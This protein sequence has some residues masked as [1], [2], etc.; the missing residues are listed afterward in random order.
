MILYTSN[1]PIQKM[2]IHDAFELRWICNPK[3]IRDNTHNFILPSIFVLKKHE[4]SECFR[5]PQ[6]PI[7]HN[8]FDESYCANM[9]QSMIFS[10]AF[11]MGFNL[12]LR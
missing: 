2:V 11:P 4:D 8:I 5:P 7:L 12:I 10:E 6:L 9:L 3:T 1:E